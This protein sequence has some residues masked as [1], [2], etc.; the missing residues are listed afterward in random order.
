MRIIH[1]N[2]KKHI[3]FDK[4]ISW[5]S[6]F[7][8]CS[9][10]MN[11]RRKSMIVFWYTIHEMNHEHTIHKDRKSMK[12][13][14]SWIT[15]EHEH[16]FN[17]DHD[18]NHVRNHDTKYEISEISNIAKN[19]VMRLYSLATWRSQWNSQSVLDHD[20]NQTCEFQKSFSEQLK[21]IQ[22]L[23]QWFQWDWLK[24]SD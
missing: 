14:W 1:D 3:N 24:Q 16:E 7:T 5:K 17:F 19:T 6:F 10:W 18:Q 9:D 22:E 20:Q 11:K 21:A 4:E 12:H 2:K 8:I 15:Y 13:C 23:C